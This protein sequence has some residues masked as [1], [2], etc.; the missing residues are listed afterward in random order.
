MSNYK[1]HLWGLLV[2]LAGLAIYSCTKTKAEADFSL[3]QNNTPELNSTLSSSDLIIGDDISGLIRLPEG[4]I[5]SETTS[6]IDFTL[7]EGYALL[8]VDEEGTIIS[9]RSSTYTCT[10]K[11]GESEGCSPFK[12]K[13]SYGC[14]AKGCKTCE[15]KAGSKADVST[16]H[17]IVNFNEPLSYFESL[18]EMKL[19]PLANDLIFEIPEVTQTLEE[20]FSFIYPDGLPEFINNGEAM[21]EGYVFVAINLYG[22][23]AFMP[24]PEGTDTESPR[25]IA[26]GGGGI[27]CKC[28]SEGS[29]CKA[30]KRFGIE[31]CDGDDCK[32]CSLSDSR[33]I[34]KEADSWQE[35]EV[36][37]IGGYMK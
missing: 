1:N 27:T 31:Y 30:K 8:S 26:T 29:G 5:V 28:S 37:W 12:A 16:E 22:T 17:I 14:L 19:T 7:P 10:C 2:L 32:S 4:T 34:I 24:F 23:L 18:D 21:P 15:G 3:N 11:S 9:A 13:G 25:L 36:E 20:F 6:G 35:Y 33:I